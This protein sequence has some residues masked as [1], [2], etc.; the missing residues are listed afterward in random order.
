MRQKKIFPIALVLFLTICFLLSSCGP[1]GDPLGSADNEC[2]LECIYQYGS[3]R[4]YV[5]NETGVH[6]FLIYCYGSG[7]ITV[8]P[9]YDENGNI[10]TE[11]EN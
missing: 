8:T 10:Y 9:R 6:Y 3:L 11:K 5:D 1:A 4:E 7:G 2:I